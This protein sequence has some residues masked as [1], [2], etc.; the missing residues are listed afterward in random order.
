M[1]Q[2]QATHVLCFSIPKDF[3]NGAL[4]ASF[5]SELKALFDVQ[6][7]VESGTYQGHTTAIAASLF[8]EVH[9]IELFPPYYAQAKERFENTKNVSVHFGDSGFVL[10]GILPSLSKKTLFYLDGHYDGGSQSG[11]G[12]ENTP[13]LEE[14]FAI[15]NAGKSDSVILIDDLCDF[16]ESLYPERIDG[17]CFENYPD[18]PMLIDALLTIHP[19]YQICFLGNALL[20]F[21]PT[22]EVTVSPVVSACAID[23]LSAHSNLFSEE[24]CSQAE[25]VIASA[26]GREKEALIL[27]SE[28]YAPFEWERG[29]RSFAGFWHGLIL[30]RRGEEGR[31][32]A[33]FQ[34]TARHSRSGW[35]VHI[36]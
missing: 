4:K 29:W 20:A 17:T 3:A 9:T 27:Y 28:V 15:R 24:E 30:K 36:K 23:R 10:R 35:R 33:L 11:K 19:G 6:T 34:E 25:G 31:A 2:P 8:D 13:V 12:R 32:H 1:F 5:L 26:S 21:P 16:Q 22:P 7:F 14:L 18:L